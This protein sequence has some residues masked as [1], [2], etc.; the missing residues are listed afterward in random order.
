[1]SDQVLK[2]SSK[3]RWSTSLE[4]FI[5][6][7]PL[8]VPD[9]ERGFVS[10][11]KCLVSDRVCYCRE[12]GESDYF[13]M[14]SAFF[15]DVHVRLHIDEFIILNVAPTQLHPNSWGYLQ[16]FWLLC[17]MFGL[18]P[19]PQSFLHY[20]SARPSIPIRW[21]SL[22]S[23]YGTVLFAPYIV[24]Y[25]HSK[26]EFFH[27]AIE[28]TYRKYCY[29]DDVPKFPFHWTTNP[30]HYLYWPRSSMTVRIR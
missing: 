2:Q 9:V 6:S 24:S 30:V 7:V 22:V 5:A 29:Y 16:C 8:V 1:V 19:S 21:V 20:Y 11:E 15:T 18:T 26:T 27:V 3:Y 28:T 14:Y 12:E 10:M 25:K 23:Q 13:F 4:Y 17:E